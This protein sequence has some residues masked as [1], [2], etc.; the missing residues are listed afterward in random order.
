MRNTYTQAS[1]EYWETKE[2]L[3]EVVGVQFGIC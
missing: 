1:G 3:R 2:I